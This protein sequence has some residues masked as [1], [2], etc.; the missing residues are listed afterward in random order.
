VAYRIIPRFVTTPIAFPGLARSS[1]W[2]AIAGLGLGL[3]QMATVGD[4]LI[5]HLAFSL[6]LVLL[7][8][9]ATAYTAVLFGTIHARRAA[10]SVAITFVL[11]GAIWLVLGSALEVVVGTLGAK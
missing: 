1:Y 2:L 5:Y 10:P 3:A 4:L 6:G 11:A 9:A 8:L 7:L